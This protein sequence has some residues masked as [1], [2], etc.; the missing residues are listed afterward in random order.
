MVP[1]LWTPVGLAVRAGGP[2]VYSIAEEV[3]ID[4]ESQIIPPLV[5]ATAMKKNH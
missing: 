2:E 1:V 5:V 3:L 4:F